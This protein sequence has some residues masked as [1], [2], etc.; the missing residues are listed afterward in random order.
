MLRL[1]MSM[2]STIR[3]VVLCLFVPGERYVFRL[4]AVSP[5]GVSG[6]SELTVDVNRAPTLGHVTATPSTGIAVTTQFSFTAPLWVDDADDLPLTY[7]T[8]TTFETHSIPINIGGHVD[9]AFP[10]Y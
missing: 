1:T 7:V 6:S 9:G 2:R 8:I 5:D 10:L 4:T 3:C